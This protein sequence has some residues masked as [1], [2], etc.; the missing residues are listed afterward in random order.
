MRLKHRQFHLRANK[1]R[2]RPRAKPIELVSRIVQEQKT[3]EA[4]NFDKFH[5]E[6]RLTILS[7]ALQAVP[8]MRH[9]GFRGFQRLSRTMMR[10]L[11]TQM[12]DTL[13]SLNLSY[14]S[15]DD[16]SIQVLGHFTAMRD[17]DVSHTAVTD[18]GLKWVSFGCSKTLVSLSIAG[19]NC[20]QV[21]CDWIA[22]LVGYYKCPCKKLKSLN[23]AGCRRMRDGAMY[24]IAQSC[25]DLACVSVKYCENITDK[26]AEHLA[27]GCPMLRFVDMSYTNMGD[28]ALAAIGAHCEHMR[29]I[30]VNRC[31]R[32]TDAGVARLSQGCRWLESVSFA[33]C[34]RLS[35]RAM[36]YIAGACPNLVQLNLNGLSKITES[37]LRHLCRGNPYL[38]PAVTYKGLKPKSNVRTL[39]FLTQQQ[40]FLNRAAEIIQTSW[41]K[42]AGRI[43]LK[44]V[45]LHRFMVPAAD[46]IRRCW[47]AYRSRAGWAAWVA[48]RKRSHLAAEC[49]QRAYRHHY[50]DLKFVRDAL[51]LAMFQKQERLVTKVQATFRGNR[52]RRNLA[53]CAEVA[54]MLVQRR[55]R[56][57]KQR[58]EDAVSLLQRVFRG[59]YYYFKYRARVEEINQ[60]GRDVRTSALQLQCSWRCYQARLELAERRRLYNIKMAAEIWA[61]TTIQKVWRGMRGRI[62]ATELR[63]A[64]RRLLIQKT[65][66]VRRLQAMHRGQKVR[67]R[68]LAEYLAGKRAALKIQTNFRG[69]NVPS[70]RQLR[71]KLVGERIQARYKEE[72]KRREK[73]VRQRLV[74]FHEENRHDSASEEE[75]ESWQEVYNSDLQRNVYYNRILNE[76][77]DTNPLDRKFEKALVGMK[78]KVRWPRKHARRS[79]VLDMTSFEYGDF[80]VAKAEP[81]AWYLGKITT[82]NATKDKHRIEFIAEKGEDRPRD[83]VYNREWVIFS[84][85]PT[86]V[87]IEVP[88]ADNPVEMVWAMFYQLQNDQDTVVQTIAQHR[89]LMSVQDGHAD[90]GQYLKEADVWGGGG[91]EV[92]AYDDTEVPGGAG[93]VSA[94]SHEKEYQADAYGEE[95]E[96]LETEEGHK[97][98]YNSRTQESEWANVGGGQEEYYA[99]YDGEGEAVYNE[100]TYYD[101]E[102]WNEEVVEYESEQM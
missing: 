73:S 25:H 88:S 61:S 19:C 90:G 87:A 32:V 69:H 20:T 85:D 67:Q 14:S 37:G 49:I 56:L 70:I 29:S 22:G 5:N 78:V 77:R 12:G 51:A 57:V 9:A 30:K 97:Y 80:E 72:M 66:L 26:G 43:M 1:P 33:G 63:Q 58:R 24:A 11:S 45:L 71:L 82:Y 39:K 95:W 99:G 93:G 16:D 96:L 54:N 65:Q 46:Q 13:Q 3:L 27:V 81:E 2:R 34:D 17:L 42:K 83:I 64:R 7:S 50:Y 52:A 28:R 102:G 21:S 94:A 47:R 41:R 38:I 8:E 6:L 100:A 10:T 23:L 86:R 84:K 101:E 76:Q 62:A 4:V 18:D 68:V 74:T 55:R 92:T 91:A 89:R 35:E 36:C 40:T 98:Y 75:E 59:K 31:I 79:Q 44:N 53:E 48:R 15:L 60:Y